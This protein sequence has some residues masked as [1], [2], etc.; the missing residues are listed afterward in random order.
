M[1]ISV[2]RDG[3]EGYEKALA[4]RPD[5][6][7][8]DVVMPSRSGFDICRDV[9]RDARLAAVPVMFLSSSHAIEDKLAGFSAGAV[10]YVTKPFSDEEVLARVFL[11]V[12]SKRR[13]DRLETMVAQTALDRLGDEAFPDDILF[14]QALEVLE[15]RLSNPPGLIELARQ[16]GTNER[17]LTDVFRERVHMTVFDYFSE[18]RLETARHLLEFSGM[19]IQA[20]AA[21]VGYRN[22]GDFTRAYRRRYDLSPRQYRNAHGRSEEAEK[23]G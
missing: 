1:A 10:D 2:A 12:H 3:H 11:H 17:K 16:L 5:L 22:A 8:M 4:V 14:K 6:M 13:L 15:G 23:Q 21:H 9:K 7:L 20:I 18:L 19:R